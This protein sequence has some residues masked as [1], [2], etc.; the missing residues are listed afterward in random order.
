MTTLTRADYERAAEALSCDAESIQA[1]TE[2]EAPMGGFLRDGRLRLLFEGHVF[3]RY[4]RGEYDKSHPD[5]SY[6]SFD[7]SKYA[8]GRDAEERGV[9]EWERLDKASALDATAAHMSA[10]VGRFQIMGFNFALCGFKTVLAFWASLGEKE[11]NHLD[12]FVA[13]INSV[14]LNDELRAHRWTEFARKYNGPLYKRNQ[15]D[16]KL[17]RAYAS[18]VA[19]SQSL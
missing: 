17:M 14:G 9:K 11:A 18:L 3:H 1:V 7:A 4:T 13:Y 8:H 12:A 10:S 5:V 15:Y 19:R 2:V 16:V 6:P